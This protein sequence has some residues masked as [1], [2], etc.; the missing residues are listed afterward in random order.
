MFCRAVPTFPKSGIN[1]SLPVLLDQLRRHSSTMNAVEQAVVEVR[2]GSM[3]SKLPPRSSR[4]TYERPAFRASL[5][6]VTTQEWCQQEY[7]CKNYVLVTSVPVVRQTLLSHTRPARVPT[8]SSRYLV[9]QIDC[10][11]QP[12]V[13][14]LKHVTI[15]ARRPDWIWH[16]ASCIHVSVPHFPRF[17]VQYCIT[18]VRM[19]IHA[20]LPP[21]CFSIAPGPWPS[22]LLRSFRALERTRIPTTCRSTVR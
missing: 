16:R 3:P 19:V 2:K 8:C 14:R 6:N 21:M 11:H 1:L 12:A 18:C 7:R 9:T 22:P 5:H 13:R 17:Q 4:K 20:L 15:F 10:P